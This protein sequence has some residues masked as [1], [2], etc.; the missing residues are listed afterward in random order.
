MRRTR[1]AAL[2]LGSVALL[3]SSAASALEY[4]SRNLIAPYFAVESG[5]PY[6]LTTLVAIRND[7]GETANVLVTVRGGSPEGVITSFGYTLAPNQVRTFNLRD[8]VPASAAGADGMVHGWVVA[9]ALEPALLSGDFFL[10]TP[11]E[12]FATGFELLDAD[13][14]Y[15]RKWSTRFMNGGAF[16]GGTVYH[17]FAP[18]AGGS[19]GPEV[20][21]ATAYTEDGTALGT[22]RVD[23]ARQ[24]FSVAASTLV[25]PGNEFGSMTIEFADG[26]DGVVLAEHRAS[27]RFAVGMTA[28]CIDPGAMASSLE[29]PGGPSTAPRVTTASF[30]G[31]LAAYEVEDDNPNGATTLIAVRNEKDTELDLHVVG[32]GAVVSLNRHYFLSPQEVKTLNLRDVLG[33]RVDPDGF[34]RGSLQVEDDDRL[35]G[36]DTTPQ[37]LSGDFFQVNPGEDFAT[38]GNMGGNRHFHTVGCRRITTRFMVGGVFSGGTVIS[39]YVLNPRGDD[40]DDPPTVVGTVYDEPGNEVGTFEIKM[41]SGP[42]SLRIRASDVVP[43]GV[44]FGSIRLELPETQSFVFTEHSASGRFSVGVPGACVPVP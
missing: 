16:S 43:A 27:G 14:A 29:A 26:T 30:R 44:P 7:G 3:I 17:V 6:G 31:L 39:A 24:S 2:F 42:H 25:P 33:G 18:F 32:S 20:F 23:S 10:V 40:P 12:D 38:G 35:D 21:T 5:N 28:N 11:D 34:R 22:S 9:Q 19:G 1:L 41:H 8:V 13:T 37:S 36:P 15:C 4:S